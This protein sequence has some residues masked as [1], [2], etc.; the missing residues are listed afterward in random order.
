MA[1]PHHPRRLGPTPVRKKPSLDVSLTGFIYT[2]MM[3]F[4]GIAA[5]NSQA[6][7]LFGVFGLMIGVLLVSGVISRLVLRRIEVR[8]LLP[9][10]I[11][12]GEPASLTY[13]FENRKRFWPSLSVTI[14]ELS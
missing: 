6:N 13:E 3:L 5:I 7:L 1:A 10:F 12:V 14:G 9:D 4:M 8:R 2:L 11:V